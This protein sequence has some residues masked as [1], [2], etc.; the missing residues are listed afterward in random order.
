MK[1]LKY[2]LLIL[3]LLIV[4]VFIYLKSQMSEASTDKVNYAS[5]ER[6]KADV[7]SILNTEKP[8]NYENMDALNQVAAY[9]Y[10]SFSGV[11]DSIS[12][13]E[14]LVDG[15]T[16]KNIIC[17]INIDKKER[18]VIGA[19][20]DV[21]GDQDGADDNASGVAGML[22]LARLLKDK[23]L[24]YRIDFV[25]YTLE[26]PP[27]FA[28]NKM[29]SYMHAKYLNDNKIQVKGMISLEMIGY[30]S[31]EENSQEYPIPLLSAL[32]GDK[33][34]FIAIVKKFGAGDFA[35]NISKEMLK[36][37][38][39]RSLVFQG[40]R[41]MLGIDFSDH[42]NY[43]NFGYSSIMI[44]NTAFFRN[45]N[46]HEETD[47]KETLDFEKCSLVINQVYEALLKLE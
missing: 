47:K 29:G 2:T 33:G 23:K 40:S 42:R 30:F 45:Q 18:I 28:S 4:G 14:Y 3:M 37:P 17:S 11:S 41:S 35:N 44:T 10:K 7:D 9:I 20:Y 39:I 1:I 24:N 43:W 8:R 13:Q 5:S 38:S 25:A 26:E 15:K 6:I 46:Y 22:E 27:Y 21:C 31:D 12:I 34:N 32:Y 16:Y 19:H 36:N